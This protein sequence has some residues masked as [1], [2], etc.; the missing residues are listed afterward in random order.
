MKKMMVVLMTLCL[1]CSAAALAETP[2][3][4]DM[5]GLVVMDDFFKGTWT[6]G[7]AFAGETY[8]DLDTLASVYGITIPAVTI[9]EGEHLVIFEGRNE[10]G[11]AVREEYPYMIENSQLECQDDQDQLF[12]FELLEDGNICLSTFVPGEGE[13]MLAITIFMVRAEAGE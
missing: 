7:T 11:E 8:V 5:P 13:G 2:S 10:N 3:F 6:A 4:G 1:L 12:V 9:D